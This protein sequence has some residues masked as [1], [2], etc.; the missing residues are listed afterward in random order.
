MSSARVW[1]A[2][3]Y[4]RVTLESAVPVR[5]TLLT[6][7]DPDRLVLDLQGVDI[8]TVLTGLSDKIGTND[9]YVKGVRIGRFRPDVVRLVFD[10]KGEVKP[11]L[12]ALAPVG[13]YGH[14]LVL[15]LYPMIPPD[16]LLAFLEK[17]QNQ[18]E[19]TAATPESQ[20]AA[21][22]PQP[23]PLPVPA[24]SAPLRAT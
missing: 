10:L 21:A 16:P 13:D 17:H 23:S 7:K 24:P 9:P 15:D 2:A 12:F 5:H 18:R 8:T 11:Q 6:L 22:K 1:P 3:D 4:T 20:V 19:E 14:R